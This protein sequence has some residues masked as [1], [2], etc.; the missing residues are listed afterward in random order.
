[1]S[2]ILLDRASPTPLYRQLAEAFIDQIRAGAWPPGSKLPPTRR[3]VDELGVNRSTAVAAYAELE[4]GGF[5]RSRVGSGTEVLA[6][7]LAPLPNAATGGWARRSSPALDALLRG[8]DDEEPVTT[9]ADPLDFSRLAP[10]P[11][12]FP[13]DALRRALDE[14]LRGGDGALLQYGTGRGEAALRAT[15]AARLGRLGIPAGADQVLVVSGAQQGLD[16]VLRAFASPG[17]RVAVESPT[18]SGILPLLGVSRVETVSVPMTDAG[19]DL[20]RL[21]AAAERGLRLFYTIPTFQNPTGVTTSREHRRRLLDLARRHELLLVEDGYED[22]L[23][24]GGDVPPPLSAIDPEAPVLYL[25]S[26]SKGLFPGARIGWVFGDGAAIARLA[27]LKR[28][29]DYGAPPLLQA[30]IE[31]LVASGEYDLHLE[32]VRRVCAARRSALRRALERH[33]PEGCRVRVPDGGLSAWVELPPGVSSDALAREAAA[34]GVLV[35]PASRF[36]PPGAPRLEALRLSITRV[37]DAGIE[38]GIRR[39]ARALRHTNRNA[40]RLDRI[41]ESAPTL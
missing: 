33:L 2:S 22:D 21:E 24:D 27:A 1:M 41:A 28:A 37:D 9:P 15:V 12:L 20:D 16:L 14:L 34:L 25:G 11:S 39:L 4:K 5:V 40:P 18:Y 36:L 32:Q 17:D 29:V 30:A 8:L 38:P 19:A 26:F 3:L 7:R 6:G 23:R 35:S 10:D 13:V 31:R